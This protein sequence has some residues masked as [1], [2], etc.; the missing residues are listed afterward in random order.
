MGFPVIIAPASDDRIDLCNQLPCGYRCLSA[1]S[2]SDLLLEVV[3]GFLS[4]IGVKRSLNG[5][6]FD[7]VSWQTQRSRPSLDLIPEKLKSL[8]YMYD[9][10]FI[11]VQLHTQLLQ[12]FGGECQHRL[13]FRLRAT[14]HQPII[15][16]PSQSIPVLR[17][18]SYVR[19]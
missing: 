9:S 13:C 19:K 8:S 6:T 14:R 2:L 15:C 5:T 18:Y 11:L 3:D 4:R 16:V 12:Q 7:L 1:S 17:K 10:S